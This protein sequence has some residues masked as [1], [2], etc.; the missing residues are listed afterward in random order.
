MKD[1]YHA[2]F[3]SVFD[4]PQH[5]HE[6]FDQSGT[7]NENLDENNIIDSYS[8][9]SNYE[10]RIAELEAMSEEYLNKENERGHYSKA[11]K[12]ISET[13]HKMKSHFEYYEKK[14]NK[15]LGH[16]GKDK[17]DLEKIKASGTSD[18][19]IAKIEVK[20]DKMEEALRK[21]EKSLES[22][23][24]NLDNILKKFK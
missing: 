7:K 13:V 2:Y 24:E 22:K 1:L 9:L 12:E 14:I 17:Q 16:L 6:A 3:D 15:G 5:Q 21:L 4:I 10:N 23:K 18:E 20:I 19:E 8:A 11:K